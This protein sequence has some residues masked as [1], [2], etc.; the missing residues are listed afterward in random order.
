LKIGFKAKKIET[1][2]FHQPKIAGFYKKL[3]RL[4]L[5]LFFLMSTHDRPLDPQAWAPLSV[6]FFVTLY[7]GSKN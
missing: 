3:K 2:F 5:L 6:Y 7:L 4:H 1:L